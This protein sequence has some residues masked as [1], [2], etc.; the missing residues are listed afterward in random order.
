MFQLG[1]PV[2]IADGVRKGETGRIGQA[3]SNKKPHPEDYPEP[4]WV[5]FD[6]LPAQ[7]FSAERLIIDS[8]EANEYI[9]NLLGEE[10]DTT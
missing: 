6:H 10:E 8:T 4:V 7:F 3:P 9:R 2:K 1:T 5:I